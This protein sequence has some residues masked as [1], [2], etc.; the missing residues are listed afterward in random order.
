M[1]VKR[2]MHANVILS[3]VVSALYI[4]TF[5]VC[6]IFG[7]AKG[8]PIRK[9]NAHYIFFY[10]LYMA[11]L[12]LASSLT[13]WEYN[14]HIDMLRL[15]KSFVLVGTLT[16][17]LTNIING[18]SLCMLIHVQNLVLTTF[19]LFMSLNGSS[20]NQR[21][22]WLVIYAVFSCIRLFYL[23]KEALFI[24]PCN[25][26]FTKY[27][28][29]YIILYDC[30]YFVATIVSP[31]FQELVSESTY[32]FF[33]D[34]VDVVVSVLCT[35]PI[36]HYGWSVIP[37]ATTNIRPSQISMLV[38]GGEWTQKDVWEVFHLYT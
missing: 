13:T 37:H 19:F 5:A 16:V 26:R 2:K 8:H 23:L 15:L 4:V 11:A 35:F 28:A 12:C 32:L 18:V 33:M 17:I 7:P 27:L 22:T 10:L 36:V 30:V 34:I 1:N 6:V 9:T 31:Y 24:L 38:N 14:G 21:I 29:G 3:S 20:T 25:P